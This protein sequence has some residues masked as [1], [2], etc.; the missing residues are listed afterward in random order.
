MNKKLYI[1]LICALAISANAVDLD[2]IKVES[3]TIEDLSVD[4]KT[5]ASTVNIIDEKVIEQINPK[6]K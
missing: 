1:S 4:K 3:S 5:E 6:Y 2:T